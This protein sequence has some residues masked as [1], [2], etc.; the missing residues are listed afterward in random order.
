MGMDIN[1]KVGLQNLT[2]GTSAQP[3]LG[4]PFG[5]ALGSQLLPKYYHYAKQGNCFW[6]QTAST[7]VDHGASLDTAAP[8]ALYNA[9]GT[10]KDLVIL[11]VT[12]GYVSGTLG[13]GFVAHC[14]SSNLVAAAT[15]GTAITAR[16]ALV[17]GSTAAVG[18]AL[19]TAT[20]QATPANVGTAFNLTPIL[21]TSA[22]SPWLAENDVDGA[23]IVQPGATYS[24]QAIAGAAG[25]SPLVV[26]SCLW[27]EVPAS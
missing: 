20:L 13:A 8:F 5:E 19:T 15:T 4:K 27:M 17:G 24:L 14:L 3:S 18:A 2:N 7:G 12:M 16:N 9:A 6:A 25:T 1:G 21:A 22:V 10:G 23:I 26:F 11:R